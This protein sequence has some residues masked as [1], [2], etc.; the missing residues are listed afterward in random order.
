MLIL[1]ETVYK[2]FAKINCAQSFRGVKLQAD[3]V[4]RNVLRYVWSYSLNFCNTMNANDKS[5]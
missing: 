4:V 1:L 3:L 2:Y 5:N